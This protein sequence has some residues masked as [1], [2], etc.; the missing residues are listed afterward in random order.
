MAF[1]VKAMVSNVVTT[2]K[3]GIERF[4]KGRI[5]LLL[6]F[7]NNCKGC[8]LLI[9]FRLEPGK[10]NTRETYQ[11]YVVMRLLPLITV[12]IWAVAAISFTHRIRSMI[13]RICP[14]GKH[15]A[16]GGKR[17]RNILTL[18]IHHIVRLENN[19]IFQTAKFA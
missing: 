6:R 3:Q 8:I 16:I 15:S 13:R 14:Q 12:I 18:G 9:L 10:D 17:Q 7:A 19:P 5:C 2:Y 4:V 1:V 11:T